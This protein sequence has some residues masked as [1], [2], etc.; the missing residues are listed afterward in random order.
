MSA[1]KLEAIRANEA[2][3]LMLLHA[4]PDQGGT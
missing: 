3:A 2:L 4:T 1:T